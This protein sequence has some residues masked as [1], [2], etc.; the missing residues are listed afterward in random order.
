MKADQ[1]KFPSVL[2][3]CWCQ[4]ENDQETTARTNSSPHPTNNVFNR[5]PQT[6][7]REECDKEWWW[8]ERCHGSGER[9]HTSS[10]LPPPYTRRR[11]CPSFVGSALSVTR[12][13]RVTKTKDLS[14]PQPGNDSFYWQWVLLL[15]LLECHS[16]IHVSVDASRRGME[17]SC[18]CGFTYVTCCVDWEL[19]EFINYAT[20]L[21]IMLSLYMFQF[22]M[23]FT[24]WCICS[25]NMMTSGVAHLIQLALTLNTSLEFRV[26]SRRADSFRSW[27]FPRSLIRLSIRYRVQI[28]MF[29]RE[30]LHHSAQAS[31]P[32]EIYLLKHMLYGSWSWFT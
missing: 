5:Y 14:T 30:H 31:I 11:H 6:T 21:V 22:T 2:F 24:S 23:L 15:E 1:S 7:A 13:S 32:M 19:R 18:W 8:W 28:V 25:D 10:C 27:T 3:T 9:A 29:Y 17:A 12:A 20:S 16:T 4:S 26:L